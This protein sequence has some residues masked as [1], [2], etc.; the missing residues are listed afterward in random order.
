VIERELEAVGGSSRSA[1]SHRRA[2]AARGGK[3]IACTTQPR[4][5][6]STRVP[7]LDRLRRSQGNRQPDS[8]AYRG[9]VRIEPMRSTRCCSSTKAGIVML[10]GA[11][12]DSESSPPALEHLRL[13]IVSSIDGIEHCARQS[14]F[15]SSRRFTRRTRR[16]SSNRLGSRRTM[17]LRLGRSSRSTTL[18]AILARGPRFCCC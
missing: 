17:S 18:R 14:P 2:E 15:S 3:C 13:R 11:D 1:M 9:D 10:P 8:F 7:G 4:E 16:S 6:N 12:D 5:Q